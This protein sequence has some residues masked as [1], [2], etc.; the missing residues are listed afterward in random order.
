MA[1]FCELGHNVTKVTSNASRFVYSE[2]I[3]SDIA[4]PTVP[5][6]RRASRTNVL[7]RFGGEG[8][9]Q[10]S[11]ATEALFSLQVLDGAL[12]IAAFDVVVSGVV[13]NAVFRESDVTFTVGRKRRGVV[14]NI[15]IVDQDMGVG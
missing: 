5:T 1:G 4:G 14:V 11:R 6:S 7:E 12:E 15:V 10:E 13:A 2:F 3:G 9:P 8:Y